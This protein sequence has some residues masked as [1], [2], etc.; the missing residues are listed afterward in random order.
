MSINDNGFLGEE[1]DSWIKKY[2]TENSELYDFYL[3][4]NQFAH[5]KVFELS[6]HDDNGQEVIASSLYMRLLSQYQSVLI[7]SE[8]GMVNEAKIILRAML[9]GLFILSAISKDEKYMRYYINEDIDKRIELLKYIKDNK[10]EFFEYA[11]TVMTKEEIQSLLLELKEKK[12]TLEKEGFKRKKRLSTREWAELSGMEEMY[13][14]IYSQFNYAVH[15]LA[16]ELEQYVIKNDSGD[17]SG[18]NWGP[19]AEGFDIILNTSA[20]V[21]VKVLDVI[22]DLFSLD[23]TALTTYEKKLDEFEIK[24]QDIRIKP[25]E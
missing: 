6:I 23:K 14:K 18:L 25:Q 22:C 7:L 17:I 1:I 21:L 4:I 20:D 24:S 2:Q 10:E 5:K 15:G 12:E 8:R 11:N 13:Y 19:D 9:D 16:R 3:D